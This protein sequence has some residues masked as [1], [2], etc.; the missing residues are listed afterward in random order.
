M[1]DF[2]TATARRRRQVYNPPMSRDYT[3][4]AARW[5]QDEPML[6]A[7]RSVVFIDEQGVPEMLEWDGLDA[8]AI[9][10]LAQNAVGQ[11]I[12]TARLVVGGVS[13]E[14]RIGRMAVLPEWRGRGVGQALLAHMV[15]AARGQGLSAV[16]LHAQLHALPFYARARFAPEGAEFT[17]AGILHRMMRLRLD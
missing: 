7:L 17:E 15:A 12:G 3:V 1:R 8:G 6:R 2:S 4:R 11:G 16:V 14:G 9:H 10:A 5:A 13:G